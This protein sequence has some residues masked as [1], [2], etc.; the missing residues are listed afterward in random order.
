AFSLLDNHYHLLFHTPQA[1]VLPRAMRHLNGVYTRVF[2]KSARRDG[3]LFRGRYKAILVDSDAY[4]L[5][6]VRYI[7]L[8]PVEAKIC[9]CP[10]KHRWTSHCCYMN[11]RLSPVWLSR[12]EVLGRFSSHSSKAKRQLDEFVCAG[13]PKE[14]R[15][16]MDKGRVYLGQKGFGEW[17]YQN[18]MGKKSGVKGLAHKDICPKSKINLKHILDQVAFAYHIPLSDLRCV[19]A[20]KRHEARSVAIYLSR[21]LTGMKQD[22]LARWFNAKDGYTIAKAQQRMREEIARKKGLKSK[23]R[24][25]ENIILSTVKP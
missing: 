6:L 8:N 23:V 4:L 14:F 20:G 10:G 12:G 16:K 15:K 11:D 21:R 24:L 7:H 22:D 2:N 9:D 13:I 3:P 25:L 5:Q 1:G 17:V 18:F 19:Q